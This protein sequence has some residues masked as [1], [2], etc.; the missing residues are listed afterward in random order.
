MRERCTGGLV[1]NPGFSAKEVVGRIYV[2]LR[3]RVGIRV[4]IGSFTQ[5]KNVAYG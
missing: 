4:L 3:I 1:K 5:D 2:G